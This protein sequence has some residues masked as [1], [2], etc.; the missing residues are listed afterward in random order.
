[1]GEKSDKDILRLEGKIDYL[2]EY[3]KQLQEYNSIVTV[4]IAVLI[5]LAT[6]SFTY[7]STLNLNDGMNLL[8]WYILFLSGSVAL[9]LLIF[10]LVNVYGL[11]KRSFMFLPFYLD[12]MYLILLPGILG[13]SFLMAYIYVEILSIELPK[14]L[15]LE[16]I[17]LYFSIAFPV[18]PSL[19]I[20]IYCNNKFY[21]KF[22]LLI[23]ERTVKK[24]KRIIT[25]RKDK[26]QNID[27]WLDDPSFISIK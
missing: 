17:I 23:K 25:K 13:M 24:P 14:T 9:F 2:T 7:A 3:S 21:S 19:L 1:M 16:Q 18:V 6:F 4:T 8:I 5:A 10:H 26:N 22:D 11:N 15:N 27:I 12:I 20:A